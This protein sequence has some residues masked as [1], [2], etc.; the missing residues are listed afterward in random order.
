VGVRCYEIFC[1]KRGIGPNHTYPLRILQS[2]NCTWSS[3]TGKVN[4]AQYPS[5]PFSSSYLFSLFS[6]ALPLPDVTVSLLGHVF[7]Y[8]R[9]HSPSHFQISATP[10]VA[11]SHPS[12]LLPIAPPNILLFKSSLSVPFVYILSQTCQA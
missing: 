10:P 12:A 2:G 5:R 6:F 3:I 8:P 1:T 9:S 7:P 11:P 4:E